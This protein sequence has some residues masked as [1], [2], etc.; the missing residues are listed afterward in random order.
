MNKQDD[1][2][3]VISDGKRITDK[4]NSFIMDLDY[5]MNI[6]FFFHASKKYSYVCQ[7][8]SHIDCDEL[9]MSHMDKYFAM[10]LDNIEVP[11]YENL[12]HMIFSVKKKKII[13]VKC[14]KWNIIEKDFIE[15]K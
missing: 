3:Y 1:D 14:Y 2:I 12:T 4:T 5:L 6:V 11:F 10:D 8:H 7:Y 9:Y 15:I 13:E